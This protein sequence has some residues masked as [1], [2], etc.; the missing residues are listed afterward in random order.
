LGN[1]IKLRSRTLQI[2]YD[3]WGWRDYVWFGI[4]FPPGAMIGAQHHRGRFGVSSLADHPDPAHGSLYEDLAKNAREATV[5]GQWTHSASRVR[6]IRSMAEAC[7]ARGVT[8]L[9]Y[10]IPVPKVYRDLLPANA[11]PDFYRHMEAPQRS[12]RCP[13]GSSPHAT[14]ST[15]LPS[16]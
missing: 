16:R 5:N 15:R 2:R 13:G 4:D 8:L 14:S 9:L 1:E 7:A 10:E 12:F 6:D 3:P 11:Y